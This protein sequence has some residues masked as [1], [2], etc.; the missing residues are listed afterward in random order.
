MT[1]SF[2]FAGVML[3]VVVANGSMASADEPKSPVKEPAKTL[4]ERRQRQDH[5]G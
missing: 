1:R 3:A 5:Q 2:C 4:T